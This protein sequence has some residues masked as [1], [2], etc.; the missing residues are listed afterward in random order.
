MKQEKD[1]KKEF[2]FVNMMMNPQSFLQVNKIWATAFGIE[3]AVF[4][5]LIVKR[6]CENEKQEVS[7]LRSEIEEETTITPERQRFIE[8][9]LRTKKI[10]K[11]IEKGVPKQPH[12]VV[13]LSITDELLN[14]ALY[15][16]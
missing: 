5:N 8:S 15:G 13:D 2:A 16:E 11:T 6:F 4:L 12:Y 7:I 10:L 14:I 1:H 9:E 3:N